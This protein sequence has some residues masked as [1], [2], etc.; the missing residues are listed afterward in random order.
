M[1]L[2]LVTGA[3]S[4]I[5]TA[6]AR[7]LAARGWSLVLTGRSESALRSLGAELGARTVVADLATTEGRRA[8]VSAADGVHLLVNNAALGGTFGSFATM[9]VEDLE[10]VLAVNVVA[11]T[12]LVRAVLPGMLAAGRG[13]IVTVSSPSAV[14][15]KA[16]AAAYGASKAFLESLDRSVRAEVRG[17]GV[18]VTTV[19]PESTRTDFH[20]RSGQDVSDVGAWNTPEEVARAALDAH[21]RGELLVRIPRRPAKH[22]A[23]DL[24]RVVWHHP[25][26]Q[27]FRTH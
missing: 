19:R 18:V 10:A 9:P 6:F 1:D 23:R 5:G 12:A 11:P 21:E 7:E 27:R 3:T 25:A 24:A 15:P 2:A 16:G 26:I 14:G 13:G 4:G 20:A 22:V 17:S 8:V